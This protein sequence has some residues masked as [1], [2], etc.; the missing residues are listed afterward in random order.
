M[1]TYGLGTMKIDFCDY[2]I[3]TFLSA[4]IFSSFRVFIGTKLKSL[5]HIWKNNKNPNFF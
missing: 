4:P 5:H 1:K 3:P 2:L